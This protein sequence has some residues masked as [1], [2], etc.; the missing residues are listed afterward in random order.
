LRWDRDF[1]WFGSSDITKSR[2]YQSLLAIASVNPIAAYNTRHIA[3]DDTKD[4]SPRIG[5]AYDLTGRGKHVCAAVSACTSA[6]PSRT[7][8]CSWS[9]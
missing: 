1:N 6:I 5:F 2:S 3:Q 8:L 9:N 7:F 4:F